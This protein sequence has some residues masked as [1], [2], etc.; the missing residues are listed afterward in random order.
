MYFLIVCVM[1]DRLYY[2]L[3]KVKVKM[4]IIWALRFILV[5]LEWPGRSDGKQFFKNI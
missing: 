1:P 3:M 4:K 2:N 5:I